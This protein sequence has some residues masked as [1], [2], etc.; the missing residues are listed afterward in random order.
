MHLCLSTAFAEE[1]CSQLVE[2]LDILIQELAEF[3]IAVD[4]SRAQPSPNL[5]FLEKIYEHKQVELALLVKRRFSLE[6]DEFMSRLYDQ[7]NLLQENKHDDASP[8][9]SQAETI[10]HLIE[11]LRIDPSK[12]IFRRIEPGEYELENKKR[13]KIT[14]PYDLMSTPVTQKIWFEVMKLA[15]ARFSSKQYYLHEQPSSHP[16]DYRPVETVSYYEVEKWIEALNHLA[17]IEDPLLTQIIPDHQ[18]GDIYALPTEAQWEFAARARGAYSSRD[19]LLRADFDHFAW[20]RKNSNLETKPVATLNPLEFNNLEFY[21]LYGNVWEWVRD[22][23]IEDSLRAGGVD[24]KGPA[25]G[26]SHVVRGGSFLSEPDSSTVFDRESYHPAVSSEFIG[27]RLARIRSKK[28]TRHA[29]PSS[30]QHIE[31]T[32]PTGLKRVIRNLLKW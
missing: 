10:G 12:A 14:K 6:K 30:F 2:P 21:D 13:I 8:E 7:I 23:H 29:S 1:S 16:G 20:N 19:F 15:H 22:F 25:S 27:F 11:Q 26:E 3:R 5:A 9:E 4:Q 17:A 18:G 28:P 31:E 32:N 24:P